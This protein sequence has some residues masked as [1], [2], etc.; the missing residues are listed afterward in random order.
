MRKEL[1]VGA[2]LLATTVAADWLVQANERLLQYADEKY[3]DMQTPPD[4]SIDNFNDCVAA[5]YPVMESYPRQCRTPGGK[6]FVE[7]IG[8]VND[9]TDLIW[10]GVPRPGDT[11]ASPLHISGQARGYW[12]FEASFPVVLTDWDGKIIAESFAT[13]DGEWMTE[14]FVPF[15]AVFSFASPYAEGDPDFMRNGTLILQKDN[16]SG[17]PEHDDAL[18]FPVVFAPVGEL[19]AQPTCVVTG[20]SGQV[21]ASEEVATT[22]E[23]RD[24]YACYRDAVCEAQASGECGWTQT[25]E[26]AQCL[27]SSGL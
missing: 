27:A 1:L 4:A 15:T 16:P 19:S 5:G 7:D 26:L 2:L 11:I 20:C 6:H 14:E 10:T 9:K 12:F 3:A 23:F 22:C 17:L 18:E 13:A 24:S 25:P 8:N 21:C